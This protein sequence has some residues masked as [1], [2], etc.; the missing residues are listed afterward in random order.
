MGVIQNATVE[1]GSRARA[2]LGFRYPLYAPM[3]LFGMTVGLIATNGRN[4]SLGMLCCLALANVLMF[5]ATDSRLSFV[6]SLVAIICCAVLKRVKKR[7]PLPL[8]ASLASAFILAALASVAIALLYDP[9]VPWMQEAN[10]KMGLRLQLGH[11][12]LANFGVS[13][14][15]QKVSMV[16]NGLSIK[17]EHT[18][19]PY[20]YV[21]C[22][23]L[24]LL[25]IYGVAFFLVYLCGM[26]HACFF[27]FRSGEIL[28]GTMLVILAIH[29]LVD[30]Q[31]LYLWANP[32][33]IAVVARFG[34]SQPVNEMLQ[35]PAEES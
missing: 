23:Y 10:A 31:G 18:T 5:S 16:G 2:C 33:L 9:S 17:G 7:A 4:L 34:D 25:I 22:L 30:N 19:K 20:N 8:A 14:F 3:L 35:A 11:D 26:S 12:G 27:S 29:G 24:Q 6:L 1:G 13:A 32:L 21:D 28:L 15:G